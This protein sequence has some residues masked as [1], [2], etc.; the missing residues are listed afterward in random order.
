[1]RSTNQKK[2]P[3]FARWVYGGVLATTLL[4][5]V[6]LWFS[7]MQS[8]EERT[9]RS[10]LY[11]RMIEGTVTRTLEGLEV[12]LVS[13]SDDLLDGDLGKGH[14][15]R[16]RDKALKILKFAPQLRQIVVIK[17]RDTLM[18]TQTTSPEN[19]NL[20]ILGLDQSV[21]STYSLGLIIGNTLKGRFL[22]AQ[23]TFPDEASLR[24]LIPIAIETDSRQGERLLIIA[25]FNPSYLTRYI[26]DL[27]LEKS[28]CVYL[29]DL[30]G[31]TLLQKGLYGPN[32]SYVIQH[33][34]AVLSEG[35]DEHWVN[36]TFGTLPLNTTAIRLL[37]KYPLAVAI[38]VNHQ[39]SF[40]LWLQQKLSLL[41]ILLIS[42]IIL[43][44]GALFVVRNGHRAMEMKAEV[45][46]LSEV[47]EHSP[48]VIVITDPDGTIEY[49]NSCFEKITGYRKDEV[50]GRN[51]RILKSGETSDT[52]YT[53]MWQTLS[54]GG[55]WQ[56][57][58]HNKHKDGSLYWERSSIGPLINEEGEITHYIALKQPITE[59][60]KAQEKLRLASAVF[61]VAAEAIMVTDQHNRIQMVNE[62]FEQITGYSESEVRGKTPS[63]L[64]SDLHPSSFYQDMNHQLEATH[65]WEGEIWNKRKNGEI[66]PQW[67]TISCRFNPAGEQEGY[68]ALFSDIT[69]RKQ[70]EAI[71]IQ[72]ANYDTLTGLCNR[73]LFEDRLKQALALSDR[74]QTKTALLY[75]DL[76]RFKYVND[77]FGHFAGDLL[78]KQVAGRLTSCIRRTDTV[79]RLGG[80]EFAVVITELTRIAS[81]EEIAQKILHSLVQTYQLENNEAYISC[82]IGIAIYPDNAATPERLL[83]NADNAMYKAKQRGR[84]T[85]EYF[86]QQLN[87]DSLR[88]SQLE[89][90]LFKA[91]ERDEFYLLYQPIWSIDGERIESVEALIRWQH[92]ERGTVSPHEFI[93]IAEESVLIHAIGKWVI[94][95]ACQFARELSDSCKHA[96]KVSINISSSQ[97]LRGDVEEQLTQEITALKLKG[98]DLII[99]ITESILL[100][101]EQKIYQQLESIVSMGVDI[102]VDDFGTGYS[103]LS[104]LKK[105]PVQR[106]KIDKSFI[107]DL[108]S[109]QDTQSLV[110]GMISLASSLSLKTVVEG[111]ETQSQLDL[112]KQFGTPMIQ[113]YL[114]ARPMT[115]DTLLTL[116]Q[117]QTTTPAGK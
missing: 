109:N 100:L 58:F 104:Y 12:S 65:A 40:F 87:E 37:T 112:L 1:M 34:K 4:F 47:V 16:I 48:T 55:T 110:S 8:I 101:E 25:T 115:G 23:G 60:K 41:L 80:D 69:Q 78:L 64:K 72:Q 86:N 89:Q 85:R 42:N 63:I 103:S 21:R 59:E 28:D 14:T 68:V 5:I 51:P 13:L 27:D 99:E 102:A 49:V 106:L 107:D 20:N 88:R 19:I 93:A 116:L 70:D 94:H 66:Y 33:L 57:E 61:S 81:I 31:N 56:G 76:D 50:I 97:F 6:V 92:P 2:P 108:E 111:V 35:A 77:T 10:A 22:P 29:T 75:I 32:R 36:N 95:E 39:G 82:S 30:E 113:G 53:K 71:I 43:I 91:L 67:L 44:V 7:F 54:T 117:K 79:A 62:S 11:T 38:V 73:H 24:E 114:L 45:A 15:A 90:D 26:S 105:Y 18:D 46:L 74:S 9:E 84:N 83:L 98:S 52:E 3:S 96:P 17:G